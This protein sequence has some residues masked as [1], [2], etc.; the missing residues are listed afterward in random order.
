MREAKIFCLLATLAVSGTLLAQAAGT[1]APSSAQPTK[2]APTIASSVDREVSIIEREFVSVAE[3][4]PE[5][6]FNF[7]PETLNIQGSDYKK[8]RTFGEQV[9]HVATTNLGLWA[10]VTGEKPAYD[11]SDAEKGP[12]SV[13]TKA[14]II[15]FLK[16]SFAAGHRAAQ[17]LTSENSSETVTTFFG[18]TPKIF[19]TT[20][21]VAHA[22]DHYGQMVEYLRMNGIVPPP[23]RPQPKK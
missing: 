9:K 6:K 8:V 1:A 3:A 16:D 23:S 4:M 17:S 13:K 10:A 14:Q 22:F 21:A 15:Q 7:T 19:A 20:F 5:D 11:V 12:Q 2:P 18:P